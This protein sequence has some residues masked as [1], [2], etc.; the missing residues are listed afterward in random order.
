ML[1]GCLDLIKLR[2]FACLIYDS[3]FFFLMIKYLS[4]IFPI[5]EGDLSNIFSWALGGLW[6]FNNIK[7][8][9]FQMFSSANFSGITFILLKI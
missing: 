1:G 5:E 3:I 8:L 7:C 4:F 2:I 6:S 9:D